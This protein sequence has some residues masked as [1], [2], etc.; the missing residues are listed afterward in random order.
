MTELKHRMEIPEGSNLYLEL[1]KWDLITKMGPLLQNKTLNLRHDFKFDYSKAHP[2]PST[3]WLFH[4]HT[5]RNC[6]LYHRVCFP[7]W[8]L[9]HSRCHECWKIVAAP[10]TV[11][12]LFK[13]RDLQIQLNYPCKCGME[14]HRPNS[15]KLY[16]AY[17]YCNSLEEGQHRYKIVREAVSDAISPDVPVILK[18]ACTEFE[19]KYVD[20]TKWNINKDQIDLETKLNECF[21]LDI[22]NHSQTH[23][24]ECHIKMSW[25]HSAFQWGDKTY[26]EFTGG[27]PLFA[28]LETYHD[29]NA[30]I[31]AEAA[32]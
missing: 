3:P 4:R 28:K 19:Q 23:H 7:I 20:S 2:D 6:L 11:S 25:I 13:M 8:G 15:D 5:D 29:V 31:P 1:A 10:R 24:Q 32:V 27:T 21:V 17:W 14:G 22:I 9:I 12:E 18:R 26:L 30:D 16:G